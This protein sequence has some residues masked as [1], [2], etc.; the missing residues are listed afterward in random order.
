VGGPTGLR[1]G[2]ELGAGGADGELDDRG[3]L[4]GGPAGVSS[5][6]LLLLLDLLVDGAGIVSVQADAEGL[7]DSAEAEMVGAA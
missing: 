3:R 5:P 6:G 4:A 1:E 2:D 7:I